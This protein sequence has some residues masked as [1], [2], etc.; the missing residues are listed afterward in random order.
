M[1]KP[2]AEAGRAFLVENAK[3]QGVVTTASGLQY[4]VLKEGE[5]R[6]PNAEDSVRVHYRGT[7]IDG[8]EFDSSYQ[9]GVPIDFP[10][11][12]VISG[13]TEVCQLMKEGSHYEVYLPPELGYG[14]R[15]AG[16]AIPPHATLIFEIEL[17]RV[18]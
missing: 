5:G 2:T 16:S 1:N 18:K 12:G 8:S 15:G 14:A 9:R 10:L 17:L 4:K 7:F 13:W 6:S 11:N 3:K